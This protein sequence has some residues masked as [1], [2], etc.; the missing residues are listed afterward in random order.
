[1]CF[2]LCLIWSFSFLFGTSL[3][4]SGD[5]CV[6]ACYSGWSPR[7]W[8]EAVCLWALL[9]NF[10]I[11]VEIMGMGRFR[12]PSKD[13]TWSSAWHSPVS[14]DSVQRGLS[15]I[16]SSATGTLELRDRGSLGAWHPIYRNSPLPSRGLHRASPQCLDHCGRVCRWRASV[17]ST[18]AC[19]AGLSVLSFWTQ[20][21]PIL[22]AD[23]SHSSCPDCLLCVLEHP[24][25]SFSSLGLQQVCR[26][27]ENIWSIWK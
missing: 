9:F 19:G 5:P 13:S 2:I 11:S 6:S 10:W 16:A 24:S 26:K 22:S 27:R 8:L 23:F 15:I 14:L 1:M 18:P 4:T 21:L 12:G 7:W 20:P 3:F 25:F 17:L